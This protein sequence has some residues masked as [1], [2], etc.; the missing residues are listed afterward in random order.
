MKQSIQYESEN[1]GDCSLTY[2]SGKEANLAAGCT[3]T[4]K[5]CFSTNS[6]FS[7]S[8]TKPND[9]SHNVWGISTSLL[10]SVD[11][12]E[13]YQARTPEGD[14]PV[15]NCLRPKKTATSLINKGVALPDSIADWH[16]VL[17]EGID[18][19]PYEYL[20]P[21]PTIEQAFNPNKIFCYNGQLLI[22]LNNPSKIMTIRICNLQG[23]VIRQLCINNPQNGIHEYNQLLIG[24]GSGIYICEVTIDNNTFNRKF[25]L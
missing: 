20:D 2:G 17:D 25:Q 3:I 7:A 22:V 13:L 1:K 11:V 24:L 23:Q 12:E 16:P 15:I 21:T 14:L 5:N 18:I 8:N 10:E 4:I 6:S 9:I 19:G